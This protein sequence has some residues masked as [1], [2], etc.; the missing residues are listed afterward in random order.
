MSRYQNRYS[1]DLFKMETRFE[2]NLAQDVANF[3]ST[4]FICVTYIFLHTTFVDKNC[5]HA[6]TIYIIKMFK[7]QRVL[8]WLLRINALAETLFTW[9]AIFTS[10]INTFQKSFMWHQHWLSLIL[11][12]WVF[13]RN[14]WPASHKSNEY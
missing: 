2:L 8:H 1:R 7:R 6:I 12:N 13:S 9:R 5:F 4:M 11:V 14:L 10:A 3:I